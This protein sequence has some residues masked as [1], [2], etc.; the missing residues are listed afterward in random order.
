MEQTEITTSV[1]FE[2]DGSSLVVSM[3]PRTLS[4]SRMGPG[5][6]NYF[7]FTTPAGDAF[8][9]TD[10]LDGTYTATI[11]FSGNTPPSVALHFLRVS[12]VIGD[13]VEPDQLPVSLGPETQIHPDITDAC[14]CGIGICGS[15]SFCVLP[16]ILLGLTVMKRHV[17]A[18]GRHRV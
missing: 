10:N 18:R 7:W 5:W 17:R 1:D 15:G 4:R 16:M 14:R 11:P 6:A 3:T 9:P 8:K 13:T 12:A 2:P